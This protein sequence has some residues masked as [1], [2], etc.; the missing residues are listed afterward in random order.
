MN[1]LLEMKFFNIIFLS[2]LLSI[3]YVCYA[4][5]DD[6]MH[7]S[8]TSTSVFQEGGYGSYQ[9][10]SLGGGVN[11]KSFILQNNI[12]IPHVNIGSGLY[13]EGIVGNRLYKDI[14]GYRLSLG[15]AMLFYLNYMNQM[16]LDS[17][18]IIARIM[19]SDKSVGVDL[20]IDDLEDTY[21]RILL[22]LHSQNKKIKTKSESSAFRYP[23]IG[24]EFG[25]KISDDADIFLG[26]ECD[27]LRFANLQKK[28]DKGIVW[29]FL[30][31]SRVSLL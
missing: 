8:N 16:K 19:T 31:G 4:E 15:A 25:R 28:Y 23:S 7:Y 26:L 22:K 17:E 14:S 21:G 20:K 5:F 24:L 11:Y 3:P 30:L 1:L 6:K 2:L 13:F 27:L 12:E 9:Y 18:S 29:S 10:L